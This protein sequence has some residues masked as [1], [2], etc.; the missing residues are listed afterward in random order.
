MDGPGRPT[1]YKEEFA[2]QAYRLCL[3]GTTNPDLAEC[4]EVDRSTVDK[5]LQRL[6]EFAQAVRRGRAIADGE[7]AHKLYAR[8][9]G[10]TYETTKVVLHNGE[11]VSVHHTVH[12]PPD[13]RAATFW[14]RNRR[15]HQWS[16]Q[17]A[18]VP[19]EEP[20]WNALDEACER[21]RRVA[22]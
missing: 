16:E 22:A 9:T 5:W 3:A 8:A 10:Y 17:A 1:L 19:D 11:P 14:L 21:A 2:E 6:P 20:A 18:R 15:P 4:F 13:V 12:C 7:V